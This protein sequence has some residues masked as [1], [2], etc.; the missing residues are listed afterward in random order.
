[1]LRVVV[2]VVAA[3][4]SPAAGAAESDPYWG[5]RSPPDDG[6]RSLDRSINLR[7]VRG[8]AVVNAERPSS[9]RDAARLLIGPLSVTADHFFRSEMRRWP[10]DRSPRT[11]ADVAR[12]QALSVYRDAPL[13]PF[14]HM[15]PL[16]PTLRVDDVLIGPDKIG[17]FFTNGYRSWERALQARQ[18]GADDDGAFRA[19]LLYG[20]D[21]ELGW[22]GLGIDGV[23]SFA[24][25]HAASAGIRF[26]DNLCSHG[27][28]VRHD[29]GRWSLE[30]LFSFSA[31]VDPC[32]DESFNTN[33]FAD[34]EAAAVRAATF[35]VCPL[36]RA[37]EVQDRRAR[38]RARGCHEPTRA[39]LTALVTDRLVPSPAAFDVDEICPGA[40]GGADDDVIAA[41]PTLP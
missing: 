33:A 5:W 29:D 23:F 35:E 26:F 3:L 21:E 27:G 36:L 30:R 10:M 17:H 12:F 6:T 18:D 8:L 37:R 13:F 9:C 25:L 24:D 15:V 32:W 34:R 40:R 39:L 16:D 22:L 20:V 1:M 11:D 38:Y 4:V 41:E 31:W 2:V 7:L 14:G 28:L 19:A